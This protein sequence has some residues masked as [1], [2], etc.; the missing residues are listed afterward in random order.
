MGLGGERLAHAVGVLGSDQ[1]I[2]H[3]VGIGGGGFAI[4]DHDD[5]ALHAASLIVVP[6]QLRRRNAEA[7]EDD[8]ATRF[9]VGA[10]DERIE[11][12]PLPGD[13]PCV[14]RRRY[15][16]AIAFAQPRERE[17]E[18]VK[19]RSIGRHRPQAEPRVAG[20]DPLGGE[21]VFGSPGQSPAHGVGGEEVE[22]RFQLV[23][24]DGFDGG[25]S[26]LAERRDG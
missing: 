15:D 7:F 19:V 6:V 17:I 11:V 2:E 8:R 1:A 24:A 13:A 4:E 22:I 25:G 16:E 10:E 12:L 9:G 3:A 21:R 5:G 20:G 23:L 14:R 18:V 26:V